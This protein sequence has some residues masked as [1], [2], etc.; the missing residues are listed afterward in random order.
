[1]FPTAARSTRARTC[2]D[3]RRAR[4]PPSASRS[5]SRARPSG[6]VHAT[7]PDD[8]ARR[9]DGSHTRITSRRA[10]ERVGM[11]RAFAAVRDPG[12]QRSA[13]RSVEPAQPREPGPRS[14][15]RPRA[16][17]A[18]YG[19]LDH[20][21][22]LND[23]HGHEAGDQALRLFSRCCAT[24]SGPTTSRPGTA[25]RSS[26]S[27]SRTA[28]SRTATTV[29]EPCASD[30]RSRSRGRIPSVHGQLRRGRVDRRGRSTMSSPSP[31]RR[32]F[33]AKA[34][35]RDRVVVGSASVAEP[36]ATPLGPPL[37]LVPTPAAGPDL[38]RMV[39]EPHL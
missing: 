23:T 22:L 8:D 4:A 7:G 9:P 1:M 30:S 28:T 17:R 24:S 11:L 20:F 29:L 14:P 25:A 32:S 27:C 26:S 2:K 39:V 31:T 16:V 21:K 36:P 34:S 35:G 3:G 15:E 38:S 19:D 33:S 6:V 18:A 10:A 37:A 5:A 12:P 13:D